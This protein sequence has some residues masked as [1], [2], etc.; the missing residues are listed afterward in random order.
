MYIITTTNTENTTLYFNE[1]VT[2]FFTVK[3]E[4][5]EK[6]KSK[7]AAKKRLKY[8]KLFAPT[9]QMNIEQITP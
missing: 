4:L 7:T 1:T 5:A 8:A 3:Q 9:T 6:Y 2:P